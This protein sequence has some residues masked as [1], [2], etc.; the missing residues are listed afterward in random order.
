MS[1]IDALGTQL[2]DESS[3]LIEALENLPI[4]SSGEFIRKT[5]TT[6]FT[7]I[8]VN[9]LNVETPSGSVNSSNVIFTVINTPIFIVV[10]GIVYFENLGYTISTGIITT[11]TPPFSYIK[12]IY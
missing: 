1:H 11:V 8:S 12:S 9:G 7:N 5:G 4:S 2:S 10:D 6:S 3:E